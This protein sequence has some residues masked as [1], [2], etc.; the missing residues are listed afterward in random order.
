MSHAP[1]PSIHLI[2]MHKYPTKQNREGV[3]SLFPEMI[4]LPRWFPLHTYRMWSYCR[5]VYMPMSYIY[6]LRYQGPVSDIV[7]Q[8]R[9]GMARDEKREG[10]GDRKIENEM[11]GVL[12]VPGITFEN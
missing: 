12:D 7:L 10:R 4:L 5:T 6:G 11:F 3:N 1:N 9:E 8:L 2:G